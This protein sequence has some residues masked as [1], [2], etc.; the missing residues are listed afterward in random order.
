MKNLLVIGLVLLSFGC[1]RV[2]SYVRPDADFAKI[3][4]VALVKLKLQDTQ[5]I[6]KVRTD[7]T[8]T[9]FGAKAESRI[10]NE[11]EL[12]QAQSISELVNDI[13]LM[14]LT[15]KFN[16]AEKAQFT[17]TDRQALLSEGIDAIIFVTIFTQSPDEKISISL[18]MHNL[19]SNKLIWSANVV[20]FDLKEI[21]KVVEKMV[22]TISP[23]RET[24]E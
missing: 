18:K 24:G 12:P 20:E 23:R 15:H 5:P 9:L 17:E 16:V 11:K 19:H 8:D 2:T 14:S 13:L 4:K 10:I 22:D 7:I 6:A 1:I 21:N 3:K